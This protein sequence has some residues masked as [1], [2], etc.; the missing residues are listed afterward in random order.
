M[1]INKPI[2]IKCFKLKEKEFKAKNLY[3]K[4]LEKLSKELKKIQEKCPHDNKTHHYDPYS[5]SVDCDDCGK[6]IE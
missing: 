2:R 1:S 4:S 3:D 5:S 6:S